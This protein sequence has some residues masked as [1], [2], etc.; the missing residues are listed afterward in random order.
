MGRRPKLAG[1]GLIRSLGGWGIYHGSFPFQCNRRFCLPGAWASSWIAFS[2]AFTANSSGLV[3]RNALAVS[4]GPY[5]DFSRY[6]PHRFWKRDTRIFAMTGCGLFRGT[7]AL[8][9]IEDVSRNNAADVIAGKMMKWG[10]S[11]EDKVLYASGRLTSEI[12]IKPAKI[13]KRLRSVNLSE[14]R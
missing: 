2:K 14:L 7:V 1:G 12:V 13:R 9:F 10:I 6:E 3:R 8:V 11:G 5:W 4:H